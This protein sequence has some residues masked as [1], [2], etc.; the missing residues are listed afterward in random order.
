MRPPTSNRGTSHG[1]PWDVSDSGDPIAPGVLWGF[2]TE[3][4]NAVDVEM[5]VVTARYLAVTNWFQWAPAPSPTGGG[6]TLLEQA[7][8]PR[9]GAYCRASVPWLARPG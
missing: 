7:R 4:G 9:R 3:D 5:F 1:V 6:K 2:S 8:R